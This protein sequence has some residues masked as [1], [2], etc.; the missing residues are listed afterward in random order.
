MGTTSYL[1]HGSDT[2]KDDYNF[3]TRNRTYI[4]SCNYREKI[5]HEKWELSRF[6]HS[7]LKGEIINFHISNSAFE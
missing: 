2:H 1:L 4:S 6:A 3:G 5:S 7:Q